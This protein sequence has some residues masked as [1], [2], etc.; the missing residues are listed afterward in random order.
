LNSAKSVDVVSIGDVFTIPVDHQRRSVGQV[1]GEYKSAFYVVVFDRVIKADHDPSLE[2][3]NLTRSEPL[4]ARLIFDSRFRP[5]MWGIIGHTV[6]DSARYLPAFTYGAAELDGV[7]VT[8]FHG[9]KVRQATEA[10]S[11]NIPRRVI[12]SPLILE[13]AVQAHHG[14][15]PWL[16]A[17]EDVRYRRGIASAQLFD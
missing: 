2:L 17:F 9:S 16:P 7:K 1:A 6:A 3:E 4:F 8:N 11:K 15:G 14:I 5:G 13:K 10:E 12:D